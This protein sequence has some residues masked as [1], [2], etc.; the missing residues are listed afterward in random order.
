MNTEG[1]LVGFY[2]RLQIIN[3][4]RPLKD[5]REFNAGRI[6]LMFFLITRMENFAMHEVMNTKASNY[7]ILAVKSSLG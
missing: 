6:G 4:L 2:S 3:I 1:M 7:V 5:N